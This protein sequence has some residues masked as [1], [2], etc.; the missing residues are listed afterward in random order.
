MTSKKV[1]SLL[2]IFLVV[3]ASI[4]LVLEQRRSSSASTASV[5]Y[6]QG[7]QIFDATG[8]PLVLRGAH[9]SSSFENYQS[10]FHN[11]GVT[12]RFNPTIFH[13]MRQNWHMNAVRIPLTNW[14]YSADPTN[15][16][17]LVDQVVQ[18][19]NA[20]GLYAILNLHDD[21]PSGSPYGTGVDTPKPESIAFWKVFAAHYAS[22]PMVLFDAFNEPMYPDG[23]T[24]LNGGGTMK[25]ST[26]KSFTVVG[27][28]ALVNAIRS[29]GA[30]QIIIIGGTAY[31]L[32]YAKKTGIQL[33]IKGSN[34]VYTKHWYHEISTGNPSIWDAWLGYF[35]AKAPYYFGEWALLPNSTIPIRCKGATMKNANQLVL[36]FLNY[37]NANHMSWTA[38]Q[39]DAPHLLL[40]MSTFTPTR[41]NDPNHSWVCNS[42]NS[43]AGMGTVVQQFLLSH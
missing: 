21:A 6:V 34:I 33:T 38:W 36:N 16:L 13:E 28:Q 17:K 18:E 41:L 40:N 4:T 24:W 30:K 31:P 11:N 12:R 35:K 3:A 2:A 20:A 1:L 26:G 32:L 27:M 23:P 43:T 5:P 8:K 10:W 9:I 29:T 39:F 19:A 15:Y 14:I 42:P 25:G 37:A 22:N 7:T